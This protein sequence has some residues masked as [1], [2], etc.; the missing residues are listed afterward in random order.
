ML[1]VDSGPERVGEWVSHAR[2]VR[3][4]WKAA[5]GEDI[6]SLDGVAIMTDADDA[7]GS[8]QAWYAAI[9]FS[10][11]SPAEGVTAAGR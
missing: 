3:A 7:G 2:D 5:F 4:D 6:G 1:A 8:A 10:A 11:E 9:R